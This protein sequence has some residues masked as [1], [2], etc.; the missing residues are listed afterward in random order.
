[1]RF[2]D[3]VKYPQR[4]F[5][6]LKFAETEAIPSYLYAF[7]QVWGDGYGG[8]CRL[9]YV[10]SDVVAFCMRLLESGTISEALFQTC[11]HT[12]CYIGTYETAVALRTATPRAKELVNAYITGSRPHVALYQADVNEYYVLQAAGR[13]SMLQ[14]DMDMCGYWSQYNRIARDKQ[15]LEK[16]FALWKYD[17]DDPLLL[18][19]EST[20]YHIEYLQQQKLAFRTGDRVY[21]RLPMPFIRLEAGIIGT[22][23]SFDYDIAIVRWAATMRSN[24]INP[25]LLGKIYRNETHHA[26]GGAE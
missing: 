11:V 21:L 24:T 2:I 16:A 8:Q 3:W 19:I 7:M 25:M 23:I 26:Y 14:I 9:R 18:E 22:I 4:T 17:L 20:H 10:V 1:M 13:I 5:N 12:L 15:W 6:H